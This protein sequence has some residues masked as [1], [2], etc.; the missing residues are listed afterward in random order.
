MTFDTLNRQLVSMHRA[1]HPNAHQQL[2]VRNIAAVGKMFNRDYDKDYLDAQAFINMMTCLELYDVN[3]KMAFTSYWIQRLKYKLP[4]DWDNEINLI[5][6]PSK[7]TKK[8][9]ER[10]MDMTA[11]ENEAQEY[12]HWE[13]E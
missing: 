10:I 9:D 6:Y 2:Y 7:P 1:G 13:D 11:L 12:S 4:H 5:R 8:R 3:G